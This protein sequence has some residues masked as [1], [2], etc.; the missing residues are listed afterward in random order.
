[1][2]GPPRTQTGRP[3][4]RPASTSPEET[5]L[6]AGLDLFVHLLE[7]RLVLD[8]RLEDARGD[9]T[10]DVVGRQAALAQ[11]F[12]REGLVSHRVRVTHKRTQ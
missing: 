2:Q 9:V 3:G 6:H 10:L 11:L 8:G 5:G 1:M 12:G 7:F 4:G